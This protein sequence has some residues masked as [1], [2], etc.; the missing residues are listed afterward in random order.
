[1]KS[2]PA[3][4]PIRRTIKQKLKAG[5]T[6]L[7]TWALI[8]APETVDIA[9]RAGLDFVIIDLEHGPMDFALAQRMAMAAE[10]NCGEAIIRVGALAESE[11][12][13]ALDVGAAG[14]IVP[15]IETAAQCAQAVAFA[16]YPPV[17]VRG[18]SPYTRAG[19][20]SARADQLAQENEATLTGVIVEGPKGLENFEAIIRTPGLDLVYVGAYDLSV[21]LGTPGDTRSPAVLQTVRRCVAQIHEN[22]K[23]SG[24]IFHTQ[25]EFDEYSAMGVKLLVYKVDSSVLHDGFSTA[26]K[27]RASSC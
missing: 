12:L 5:E 18:F 21:A 19:G 24:L 20:Y 7:G 26:A 25:E 27:M 11:I 3:G 1:M 15:H 22:G 13:K 14:V 8:P 9:I 16:K 17:G 10:A 2:L 23:A 6:T 4:S